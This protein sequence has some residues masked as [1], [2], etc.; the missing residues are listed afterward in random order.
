MA[1]LLIIIVS[2]A[3]VRTLLDRFN[4]L[5][6]PRIAIVLTFSTLI[7]LL[8][9][10]LGT[11]L[12]ITAIASIAVFPMLIMTTLAEKFV[13]ALGGKGFYAA[14][15]LMLET[16]IV[17]LICY[18]VVEWH[19]LQNLILGHPEIILLLIIFNYGLG[20][21]TGLRLM[22]YVRFREVMK[23]AEE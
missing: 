18:W 7:I 10:A 5:H 6:I 21:W 12:G 4:L 2:G 15:L 11:Y 14:F 19:Y 1:I 22:E 20:R 8:T 13:S 17:S 3:L 23:H 9:L 16:T